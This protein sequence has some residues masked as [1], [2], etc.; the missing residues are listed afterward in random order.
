[1]QKQGHEGGGRKRGECAKK[2]P[3]KVPGK[4]GDCK[5][6]GKKVEISDNF[7]RG[8]EGGEGGEKRKKSPIFKSSPHQV[9]TQVG[10]Q[11]I[12]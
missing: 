11:K 6:G 7:G 5:G 1:M 12:Q 4:S 10:T 9:P 8:E 3:K 2:V